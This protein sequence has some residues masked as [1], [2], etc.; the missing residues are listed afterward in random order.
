MPEN[1]GK[2]GGAGM[3][4]KNQKIYICA[5]CKKVLI[6]KPSKCPRCGRKGSIITQEM[7][8]KK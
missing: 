7:V 4:D 5:N 1:N 8:I 6:E 2:R 3:I